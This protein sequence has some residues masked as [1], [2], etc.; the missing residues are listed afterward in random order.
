MAGPLP[1]GT[2]GALWP[3]FGSIGIAPPALPYGVV[4]R[5]F[6]YCPPTPSF[7]LC[8]FPAPCVC[9]R[10]ADVYQCP[11]LNGANGETNG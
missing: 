10:P 7:A 6:E 4:S 1:T 5:C 11:P 9:N 2:G 8:Y 3:P